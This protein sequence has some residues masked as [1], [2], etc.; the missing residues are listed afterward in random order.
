MFDYLFFT[1]P[2]NTL[3]NMNMDFIPQKQRKAFCN[4]YGSYNMPISYRLY[5]MAY[6]ASFIKNYDP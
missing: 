2:G 3:K 6:M 5:D 4:V 1:P